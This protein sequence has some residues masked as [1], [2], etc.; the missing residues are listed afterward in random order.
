MDTE[1]IRAGSEI[2]KSLVDVFE[3]LRSHVAIV[4]K[5]QSILLSFL[6]GAGAEIASQYLAIAKD[7]RTLAEEIRVYLTSMQE[8][9]ELD[10][11]LEQVDDL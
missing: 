2:T 3:S 8:L 11:L 9:I 10:K 6:N 7:S 1:G 4:N 5:H